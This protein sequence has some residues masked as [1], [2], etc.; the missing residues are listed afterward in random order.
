[1][2]REMTLLMIMENA[3]E[4]LRGWRVALRFLL[5]VLLLLLVNATMAVT[6]A[7]VAP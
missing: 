1:L 2:C 6:C 3:A 7:T 4:S 5:P